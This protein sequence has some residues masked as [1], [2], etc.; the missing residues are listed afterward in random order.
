MSIRLLPYNI[1]RSKKSVLTAL[2]LSL[3]LTTYS[4]IQN[5][6]AQNLV[7]GD[8][9][10][11]LTSAVRDI[12]F[13]GC[14]WFVKSGYTGPGPNYWS[15]SEQSV[16]VDANGRLRLKI[17]Q[18]GN[19]WHCA[20]VYTQQFNQYGEHC[21]LIEGRVDQMDKNVVLGL[22]VYSDDL[23]EI[24]IEFSKWGWTNN[25]NIGS[26]TVQ[27]YTTPGNT[28]SFPIHLDS[29]LSTHCFNWHVDSVSFIS[30]QGHYVDVPLAEESYIHRWTYKGKDIPNSLRNLRTRMNLWLFRGSSPVDT[31]NL[32]I[33]ITDMIQPL[34]SCVSID[35]K[36]VEDYILTQNYPNP[37][38]KKTT[39][40]FSL[41][42]SDY[43]TVDVFNILG[44][45]LETLC[46]SFYSAGKYFIS[47]N[48]KNLDSGVYFYRIQGKN[49]SQTKKMILIN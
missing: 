10:S 49:F 14:K 28:E 27:P 7:S 43:V 37:F 3:L 19:T 9:K 40:S 5:I 36:V 15:D 16:W 1:L 29:T 8:P 32:E 31:S 41:P 39:I 42:E 48:A 13:A 33:I 6:N 12:D 34:T 26:Y 35:Q 47:F 4:N 22:F 45:K 30:M 23:N 17:R 11:F 46:N 21:F 44:R 20:E 24:D 18:I 25:K 38:N 2:L